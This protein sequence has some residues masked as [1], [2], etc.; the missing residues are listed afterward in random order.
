MTENM[1]LGKKVDKCIAKV[2]EGLKLLKGMV[3]YSEE[4]Q[5]DV[6][7]NYKRY[8]AKHNPDNLAFVNMEWLKGNKKRSSH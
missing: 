4:L 8:F 7:A 1:E 2:E 3:D 5:V 6:A